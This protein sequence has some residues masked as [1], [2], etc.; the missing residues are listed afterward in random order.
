MFYI[1]WKT[2]DYGTVRRPT[3]IW[4]VKRRTWENEKYEKEVK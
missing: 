2:D 1:H 4:K 3:N